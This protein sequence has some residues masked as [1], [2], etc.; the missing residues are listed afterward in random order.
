LA[1]G[2]TGTVD[3][4]AAAVTANNAVVSGLQLISYPPVSSGSTGTG[5]ASGAGGSGGVGSL[6]S[7]GG[8]SGGFGSV[9]GSEYG[10]QGQQLQQPH[11]AAASSG[12][13][14]AGAVAGGAGQRHIVTNPAD[15]PLSVAITD[16]HFLLLF[17]H[18]LV[19]VS[20]V[21][22]E[23]VQELPLPEER[24]GA[25]R[26][27]CVD[28]AL[29]ADLT[30]RSFSSGV[31]GGAAG[32]SAGVSGIGSGIWLFSDRGVFSLRI[33][34]E[35]RDV[36]RL[37]LRRGD[38]DAALT[39]L[40]AAAAASATLGSNPFGAPSGAS[41]GGFGGGFGGM[42]SLASL[43]D[44]P[45]G[46]AAA[47]APLGLSGAELARRR[48]QVRAAQAEYL[49]GR[50]AYDAAARAWREAPSAAPFEEVCLKFIHAGAH[51]ALQ[52]YVGYKLASLTPVEEGGTLVA[53]SAS[54]GGSGGGSGTG[55]SG[56]GGRAL[57]VQR[58][59]LCTWLTEMYLSRLHTLAGAAAAKPG[60]PYSSSGGAS[61]SAG[62]S[63]AG[64]IAPATGLAA[65]GG[66]PSS[67]AAA[68]A[69]GGSGSGGTATASAA[70]EALITDFKRF[71]TTYRSSL[72]KATTLALLASHGRSDE[73]LFFCT[74]CRDYD[75]VVAHHLQRRDYKAA[76]E[77]LR[78]VPVLSPSFEELW[79]S[80][81]PLLMQHLPRATADA[82]R[83]AAERAGGVGGGSGGADA[84]GG[85]GGGGGLDPV[86][87]IPA[88]VRYEQTRHAALNAIAA[89]AASRSAGPVGLPAALG[90]STST[91]AASAAAAAGG[92]VGSLPF[93]IET[94][95]DFAGGMDVA[96]AFCEWIVARGGRGSRDRALHNFLLSLYA[97]QPLEE[98]CCAYIDGQTEGMDAVPSGTHRYAAG[99]SAALSPLALPPASGFGG[100]GSTGGV[101]AGGFE[102]YH[103]LQ[104]AAA[105]GATGGSGGNP[106]GGDGG[107]DGSDGTT[108]SSGR[109]GPA[110][111]LQFAVRVCLSERKYRACAKLFTAMGLHA[112]AVET[113][114]TVAAHTLAEARRSSAAAAAAAAST[115]AS[116]AARGVRGG[117]AVG[118]HARDATNDANDEIDL[119]GL[120]RLA[121]AAA[122]AIPDVERELPLRK[123][124]WL[125]IAAWL[126]AHG[127]GAQEVL[128]VLQ[129]S[130]G[131]LKVDDVL[132][133]FPSA[134]II[135]EFKAG[136]ASS[137]AETQHAISGL[138][139]EMR[140]YQDAADR[141]RNDI[142]SL[143]GRCAYVRGG[144]RCEM[145]A[146]PLL[147]AP[148][149]VFPCSHAFHRDCL[150]A[151][152][153]RHL[154][155]SQRRNVEA[156][157]LDVARVSAAVDMHTTG[158]SGPSAAAAGGGGS[159]GGAAGRAAGGR[160]GV[161]LDARGG[162]RG[163]GGAG[164]LLA[165]M[166]G[167]GGGSS[168]IASL[169]GGAGSG[170]GRDG[171]NVTAALA[172]RLTTILPK[173]ATAALGTSGAAGAALMHV[174]AA[175]ASA[176]TGELVAAL[177]RKREALQAALDKGIAGECLFC[178]DIMIYSVAEPLSLNSVGAVRHLGGGALGAGGG[179]TV[180]EDD[181]WDV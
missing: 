78:R 130:G 2:S 128:G 139:E 32:A 99:G 64:G 33:T 95:A 102:T 126:V 10:A 106:F 143:R 70:Y 109:R 129:D 93:S 156:L 22:Q 101:R 21:S 16:Y 58:T 38:F 66:G 15:F 123:K 177:L 117:L 159:G 104:D 14:S 100:A 53:T 44:G 84:G 74:L 67:T 155:A 82:W 43:L 71:L 153:L 162:R 46:L 110:F 73:L 132:P 181:D 94:S 26:G 172:A 86:R 133:V 108:G 3:P 166:K 13:S 85:G 98:L 163:S 51:A 36:W 103:S 145:C 157:V 35:D 5:G 136:V 75:R 34:G 40:D 118:G 17:R 140:G 77:A 83:E 141:I 154:T 158:A 116:A 91:A 28:G 149:Y 89:G 80:H 81:S 23:V 164:G 174:A 125:R 1:G 119:H 97:Q 173:S 169:L 30:P 90:G 171:S 105:D 60:A 11:A 175:S 131:A 8:A 107:G 39:I 114:L 6:G 20:R 25:M 112:E 24:C 50:G 37:L 61:S 170:G 79:Y 76:L 138:K 59:V 31:L 29:A 150:L 65:F 165:G 113:A 72:D 27:M 160:G 122:N 18:R 167:I 92:A 7:P 176:S 142:R 54:A 45:G 147:S 68:A 19:A 134:S 41:G 62:A 55:G 57:K 52:A 111:D 124:V 144:Q 115:A 152:V 9:R 127:G 4:A 146:A 161:L 120:T 69:S 151:E 12:S 148:F 47:A 56:S 88:M 180:D 168:G 178:G 96:L 42:P 137:L 87:L 63:A 135:N 179:G 121:R 48:E 49:M